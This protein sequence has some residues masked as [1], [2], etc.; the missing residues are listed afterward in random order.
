MSEA[1]KATNL[2]LRRDRLVVASGLLLIT[3]L[4]WAYLVY[5]AWDMQRMDMGMAMPQ[6]QAWGR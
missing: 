5:L 3:G 1:V 6:T 4:S 2:I